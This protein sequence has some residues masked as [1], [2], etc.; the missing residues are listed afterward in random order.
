MTRITLIVGG[1]S[2]PTG[3]IILGASLSTLN[4][5]HGLPPW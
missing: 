2:V 4:F 5:R 1:A 3:L